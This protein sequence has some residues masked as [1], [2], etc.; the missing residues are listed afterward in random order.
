L[1]KIKKKEKFEILNF[2]KREKKER[3]REKF[4][5]KMHFEMKLQHNYSLVYSYQKQDMTFFLFNLS[6][7]SYR[8]IKI[9]YLNIQQNFIHRMNPKNFFSTLFTSF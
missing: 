9:I 8:T 4:G 3:E 6:S 7:S 1:K 5:I 2:K